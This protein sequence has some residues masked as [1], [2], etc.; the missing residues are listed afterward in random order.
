MNEIKT[1]IGKLTSDSNK[2]CDQTKFKQEP[3]T[4]IDNIITNIPSSYIIGGSVGVA[5]VCI[6]LIVVLKSNLN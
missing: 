3:C 6:I 4:K 2:T 1:S 5:L